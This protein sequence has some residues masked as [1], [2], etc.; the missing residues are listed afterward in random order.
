MDGYHFDN[1]VL[2]ER[3]LLPRKG[4]PETFDVDGLARDLAR[5]RAGARDVAVPVFDR[6]LDLARAG[7]RVIRPGHALVL[8]EGNYLLLD[9]APWS[10]LAAFF[11]RTLFIEVAGGRAAAAA[12]RALAGARPRSGGGAGAGGKQ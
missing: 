3:G 5:I 6:G 9:A 4:A 8:V 11:D 7:A 12:G 2:A 10:A 1:A